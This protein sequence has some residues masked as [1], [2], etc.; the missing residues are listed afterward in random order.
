[1]KYEDYKGLLGQNIA[2]VLAMRQIRLIYIS[3]GYTYYLNEGEGGGGYYLPFQISQQQ[4]KGRENK[5][6]ENI[7]FFAGLKTLETFIKSLLVDKN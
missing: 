3:Y 5:L 4:R 1:M 6:Y 2:S 7:L